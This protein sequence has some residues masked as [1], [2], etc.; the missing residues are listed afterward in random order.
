MECLLHTESR[1]SD[2][3]FEIAGVNQQSSQSEL[4]L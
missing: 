3:M 2:L 4:A 1:R